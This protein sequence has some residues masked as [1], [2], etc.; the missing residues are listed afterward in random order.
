MNWQG[1]ADGQSTPEQSSLISRVGLAIDRGLKALGRQIT[2][3][4]V[5]AIDP[6]DAFIIHW[7]LGELTAAK[8]RIDFHSLIA[9]LNQASDRTMRNYAY[10]A[11]A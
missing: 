6:I 9:R 11:A 4:S 10:S 1:Q 7:Q 5:G 8:K 2:P 3:A